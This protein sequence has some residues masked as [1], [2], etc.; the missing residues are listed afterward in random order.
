[1]KAHLLDTMSQRGVTDTDEEENTLAP[2]L[3]WAQ[4]PLRLFVTTFPEWLQI[5]TNYEGEV[6]FQE[7]KYSNIKIVKFKN[8]KDKKTKISVSI[9]LYRT[10]SRNLLGRVFE[11]IP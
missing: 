9:Y 11:N 6:E 7:K 3:L 10:M 1:M 5:M 4:L 8:F 2:L